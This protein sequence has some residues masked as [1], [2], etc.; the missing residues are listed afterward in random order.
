[1]TESS[2]FPNPIN[3]K[4]SLKWII[5]SGLGPL[6]AIIWIFVEG[7]T[8]DLVIIGIVIMIFLLTYYWMDGRFEINHR[9]RSVEIVESGVILHQRFGRKDVSVRWENIMSISVFIG[10]PIELKTA[11]LRDATLWLNNKSYYK[12]E[13]SIALV[14]REDYKEKNGKYPMRGRPGMLIS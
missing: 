10:N 5:F 7:T 4:N 13:R 8:I 12:I 9:P 11:F 6:V 1:M 14:V 3:L 2:I